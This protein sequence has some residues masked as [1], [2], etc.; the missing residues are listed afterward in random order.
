M[1]LLKLSDISVI[2]PS[3]RGVFTALDGISLN[4]NPGEIHG[5]VGESGAGKSTVGSSIMG[6][7]EPPGRVSAGSIIFDGQEIAGQSESELRKHRGCDIGMIFQD[8]MTSLDP[9]FT[10]ADQLVETIRY[11]R[12][13]TK[14]AAWEEAISL[15][16]EVD[17][18]DPE[19]RAK[20]YPHQFSG[21]MRQRVVIALAL[22]SQ[23][24]LLI[25][26][27]P[28]TALDVSVQSQIL[29]LF[30]RLT[31]EHQLGT[32]LITHDMG[33]I[34]ETTDI[35]SV[36]YRGKVV[37]TGP[38]KKII[39]TPEHPY[40]QSLISAVPRSD[41]KMDRFPRVS[42]IEEDTATDFEDLLKNWQGSAHASSASPILAVKDLTKRFQVQ[43]SIFSRSNAQV[44]AIDN[45]SF[46]INKGEIF[47]IVGESGSGKSTIARVI[48]RL[49]E[50]TE[51]EICFHGEKVSGN[52]AKARAAFFH[53]SLQMIF[54]DPYSSMNP[55][56]RIGDIIREPMEFYKLA[57]GSGAQKRVDTLLNDLGLGAAAATK[58]P[59]QFSGGQR[60]RIAI[61]R[62]LATE[63]SFLIC[64]EPTSALD[65]SVQAQI[66]NL[67]KELQEKLGLTMLFISHDLPVMR[68]MCNRIAVM[69][70]GR[71]LE[72]AETATLFE[73]PT[74]EY[75]KNLLDLMPRMIA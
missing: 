57:V 34:A 26:D 43:Q 48:T 51:G 60:Q 20:C 66:L 61:A 71:I 13:M 39:T 75:T 38:T 25:A 6:L 44:T 1:S 63:P 55:R 41:I 68:Q 27:E 40:T 74:H 56:M 67:L 8:P 73:N 14:Q 32:I 69:K 31:D 24:K 17:I 23:P 11:H 36:M 3:R 47:G 52:I 4:I 16:H 62:A 49:F 54:Q 59:H 33:V 46:E 64:D 2:Y 53:R 37:E 15:L 58:Y 28:T 45:V 30:K 29:K 5:V 18:P 50:P 19:A 35:V 9:L 65:V 22:C 21:G 70:Q 42:Y 12:P 10:V 7:L 72:T